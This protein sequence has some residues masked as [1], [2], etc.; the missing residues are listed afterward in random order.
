MSTHTVI[1]WNVHTHSNYVKCP[2]TQSGMSQDKHEHKIMSN[3]YSC[4]MLIV[5]TP[6]STNR[7]PVWARGTN[8][9]PNLRI[10]KLSTGCSVLLQKAQLTSVWRKEEMG[11]KQNK[12]NPKHKMAALNTG[13]T[14]YTPK[15]LDIF[16][17]IT[18][19]PCA[20]ASCRLQGAPKHV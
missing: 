6:W 14:S 11:I 2:H 5:L 10:Y 18:T 20:T 9:N 15:S 19:V 3:S 17:T 8:Y 7:W 4:G 1:M 16:F 12:I 13:S